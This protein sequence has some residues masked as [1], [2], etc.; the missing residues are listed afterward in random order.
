M[1]RPASLRPQRAFVGKNKKVGSQKLGIDWEKVQ[2]SYN[3]RFENDMNLNTLQR[4]R[5][6]LWEAEE[7]NGPQSSK[8][9]KIRRLINQ[10]LEQGLA[11]QTTWCGSCKQVLHRCR[12]KSRAQ[13]L[14]PRKKSRE[15]QEWVQRTA[16]DIVRRIMFKSTHPNGLTHS[17]ERRLR[18]EAKEAM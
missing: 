13:V 11:I 16:D 1:S 5:R 8:A 12:C 6:D 4:L 9:R 15:K 14:Q 2:P 7:V 17:E 3:H 10:E 18:R